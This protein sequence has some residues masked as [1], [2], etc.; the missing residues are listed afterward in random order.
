MFSSFK[1]LI[2]NSSLLAVFLLPAG[3]N[4][5]SARGADL[6][7]NAY[8]SGGVEMGAGVG[9][10]GVN[11]GVGVGPQGG[12]YHDG[13]SSPQGGYYQDSGSYPQG[14]YYSQDHQNQWSSGTTH[15]INE[16]P[17]S[18][19]PYSQPQNSNVYYESH[20]GAPNQYPYSQQNYYDD[21]GHQGA[22]AGVHMNMR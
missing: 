6:R 7:G 20:P 17:V 19:S 8:N 9:D 2:V 11:V 5:V 1:S 21:Q 18:P 10:A 13:W 16:H 12:Q 22:G 3:F 4:L 15:Y 14:G